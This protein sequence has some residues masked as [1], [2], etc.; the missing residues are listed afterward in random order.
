MS[1]SDVLSWLVSLAMLPLLLAWGFIAGYLVF[2][3]VSAMLARLRERN[4]MSAPG[5]EATNF[6]ILIPAHDEELVIEGCLR[7]LTSFDYPH[8]K[9]RVIVIADNCTDATASLARG[10]GAIVYERTDPTNRG[11]GYALNWAMQKL[12]REDKGWTGAV[13]VFD[14]DTQA[15][16]RFLRHMDAKLKGG[17]FVLQGRYDLLNPFDNWRTALL[18]SALILHNRVRPLARQALGWTTLLK[19]NGMCFARSIVERYGWNT[20]GLAEDIEYT[21]MLLNAGVRVESVPGALLYAQAPQ[22][23]GQANSQRM[24]WEGGRLSAARHDGLTML[25]DF[26]RHRSAAKLDWAMDLLTPP[27]GILVGV[28]VLML[29]VV[30]PLSMLLPGPLTF[31]GWAW[32]VVLLGAAFYVVGGLLVSNADRRAYLYLLFTPFFLIWKLRI[33]AMMLLGRGPRGWVR[34]ERT[35]MT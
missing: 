11:K 34:T 14:A 12:L 26:V 9:M 30:V 29:L 33:Y 13:I 17:S 4:T 24:R 15:D 21:T 22:T 16:A 7:S 20:Y 6:T 1:L 18:Y 31:A 19:G 3:T 8:D 35:T 2:L 10:A 25:R 32:L 27:V 28:P 23:A 5:Q